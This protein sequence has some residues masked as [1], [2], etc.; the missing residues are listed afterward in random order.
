[1]GMLPW[2]INTYK[3]MLH[4]YITSSLQV[5]ISLQP[6]YCSQVLY[7]FIVPSKLELWIRPHSTESMGIAD[8]KY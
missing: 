3:D 5:F 1:M 7:I 2:L 4:V 6:K 8:P